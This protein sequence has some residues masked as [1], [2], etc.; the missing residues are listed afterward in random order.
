MIPTNDCE[1]NTGYKC[2]LGHTRCTLSCTD[3][4]PYIKEMPDD[5]DYDYDYL[6]DEIG[7]YDIEDTY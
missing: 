4:E 6:D 2:V 1:Y 7:G 5:D 3:Y